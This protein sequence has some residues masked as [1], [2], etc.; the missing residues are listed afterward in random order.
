MRSERVGTLWCGLAVLACL[1]VE[2][3]RALHPLELEPLAVADVLAA[4][5]KLLA[6]KGTALLEAPADFSQ[7]A[8]APA[9]TNVDPETDWPAVSLLAD[10]TLDGVVINV[11]D[12][13]DIDDKV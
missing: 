4:K 2:G 13:V 1:S 10:W 5:A 8:E 9:L 11:D 3:W 6:V 7:E 12:E